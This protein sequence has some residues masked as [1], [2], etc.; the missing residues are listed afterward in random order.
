MKKIFITF[1]EILNFLFSTIFCIYLF[2]S[3]YFKDKKTL[4]FL[5]PESGFGPSLLKPYLLS[6]YAKKYKLK[7]YIL[8]FGYD[9]R[10]HNKYTKYFF[11][12]NFVWLKLNFKFLKFG[13]VNFKYKNLTFKL[14]N[15][16]IH[17][18]S[19]K[20]AYY[21]NDYFE[22]YLKVS[23]IT[24][25]KKNHYGNTNKLNIFLLN[26]EKF[27]NNLTNEIN[28]YFNI[29]IKFKKKKCAFFI[30][31]K[32]LG[33]ADPSSSMR[34]SSNIDYYYPAIKS[35]IELGWQ[36]F[37]SGDIE[38]KKSWFD[39]F[40]NNLIY[41]QK[42]NDI[43]LYNVFVGAKANCLIAVGSGPLSYKYLDYKKS[44][45]VIE[46]VPLGFGWYKSTV[47][48]KFPLKKKTISEI[49]LPQNMNYKKKQVF[50]NYSKNEI[51]KIVTDYL[52]N[53]KP[54]KVYGY[55]P[56]K[57]ILKDNFYFKSSGARISK[58]WIEIYKKK[59]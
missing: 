3:I 8:I 4:I 56:S 31:N 52:K 14:M 38:F 44:C 12:E 41:P 28:K 1:F 5:N 39:N 15:L 16:L 45:L 33:S 50:K 34:N 23:H 6:L 29:G 35:A 22:K 46:G 59:Y 27:S 54:G 7:K 24:E 9:F 48:Y 36:V 32:G 11:N 20:K 49:F 40:G 10:R 51:E 37:L 57:N 42:F 13:F 25:E 30:R 55:L 21:F 26:N 58:K 53:Y 43:D 17:F 47:A 19:N 18:F 2:L